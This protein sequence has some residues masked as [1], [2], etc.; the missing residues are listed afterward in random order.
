LGYKGSTLETNCKFDCKGVF[1]QVQEGFDFKKKKALEPIQSFIEK[2]I[3]KF[4][5]QV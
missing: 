5:E 1:G 4:D 2:R 3:T